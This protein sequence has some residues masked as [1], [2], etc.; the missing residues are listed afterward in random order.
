MDL[1][2]FFAGTIMGFFIVLS[3]VGILYFSMFL[4]VIVW[5]VIFEILKPCCNKHKEQQQL[6]EIIEV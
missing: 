2:E 6:I 5:F 4:F 1:V 3:A